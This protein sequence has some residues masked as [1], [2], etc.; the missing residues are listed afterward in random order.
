MRALRRV[1]VTLAP[2]CVRNRPVSSGGNL[3]P[4]PFIA[5]PPAFG[6]GRWFSSEDAPPSP[7]PSSTVG[8]G[9]MEQLEA[10]KKEVTIKEAQLREL[11]VR[12]GRN[13]NV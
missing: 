7:S 10:L 2:L 5:R 13:C 11:K 4:A 9:E 12:K 6:H 3:L 1:V 8:S